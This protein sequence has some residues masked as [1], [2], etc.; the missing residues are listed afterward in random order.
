[1]KLIK[2]IITFPIIIILE[3][4]AFLLTLL[5][6]TGGVILTLVAFV[7]S[8]YSVYL[9]ATESN[10]KDGA[11]GIIIATLCTPWGIPAIS[12]EVINLLE[13]TSDKLRGL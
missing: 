4:T 11:I 12:A 7:L 6:I 5:T 9:I 3:V 8:V 2:K 1:M 13:N 10:F